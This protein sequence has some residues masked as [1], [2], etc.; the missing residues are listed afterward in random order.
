[1]FSTC[2]NKD[3]LRWY[4][5]GR[6]KKIKGF[7]KGKLLEGRREALRVAFEKGELT[8]AIA[9]SIW[10]TGVDFQKLQYLIR[11]DGMSSDILSTQTPGRLSRTDGGDKECGYLID[12]IDGF[13]ETLERRSKKRLR[14]YK[15]H[16]WEVEI[17][18]DPDLSTGRIISKVNRSPK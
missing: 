14:H 6:F 4:H 8:K 9:T 7:Y 16:N 17:I 5:E 3:L 15:H 18:D 2:N 1:V 11:A 10:N 12:F 13:N